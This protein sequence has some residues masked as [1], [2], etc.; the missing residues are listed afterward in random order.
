MRSPHQ[1]TQFTQQTQQIP[2]DPYI[3]SFSSLPAQKII[4]TS[5]SHASVGTRVTSH[6]WFYKDWLL[7]PLVICSTLKYNPCV[8]CMTRG[9]Q[10]VNTGDS[11]NCCWFHLPKVKCHEFHHPHN[12]SAGMPSSPT[13]SVKVK[14]T[15]WC[16]TLCNPMDYTCPWN[17]P[18]QN[19][20]LGSLSLLQG[21]FPTQGSNPCLPHC[22][23]IL[24]QLSY[25]GSPMV[26][27]GDN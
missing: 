8:S 15:Q 22:R 4:Q 17:S 13:V 19:T 6:S 12:P 25:K 2:A 7:P 21:I 1:T 27:K 14:V 3:V 9:I 11:W 18:G 20:G 5:Q 26:S 24:Y 16:P 10:A 23:Q